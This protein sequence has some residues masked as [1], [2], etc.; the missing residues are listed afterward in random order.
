MGGVTIVSRECPMGGTLMPQATFMITKRITPAK[1]MRNARQGG[2]FPEGH[3]RL[4]RGGLCF[5]PWPRR[6]AAAQESALGQGS[7]AAL[8]GTG[9]SP[10]SGGACLRSAAREQERGDW[11][12]LPEARKLR[13]GDRAIPGCHALPAETGAAVLAAGRSLRTKR[14]RGQRASRLQK[15]PGT[16]IA[17]RLTARKSSSASKSWKANPGTRRRNRSQ[18][19]RSRNFL[20]RS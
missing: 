5:F 14:G 7:R 18:G 16:F 15:V 3:F 17:P 11:Q 13:R 6:P 8:R 1:T 12:L 10:G 9:A 20:A 4:I 19:K 2:T